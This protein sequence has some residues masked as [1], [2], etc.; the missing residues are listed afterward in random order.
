M[1]GNPIYTINDNFL[2]KERVIWPIK[3]NH[4]KKIIRRHRNDYEK[5][6]YR[7]FI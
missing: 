5:Q 3:D 6:I 1:T 7:R 2:E 4:R